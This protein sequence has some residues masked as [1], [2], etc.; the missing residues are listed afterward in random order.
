MKP[1]TLNAW[2]GIALLAAAAQPA[3]AA[4]RTLI[5]KDSEIAFSVKQMGVP[6]SGTFKRFEASIDLDSA[7]PTASR[8]ELTVDIASLDTGDDD[9]D[10]VAL[11]KP[12]LDKLGFPKATF[13]SS[14]VRAL[15]P[16]RYEATGQLAI[17]GKSREI[18]VPFETQDEKDG[19]TWVRGSFTIK[20]VDY[21]IGGGE[22]NQGDLVAPDV[23]VKFKL[24]LAPV[25]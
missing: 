24:K 8:A 21:G 25:R 9:A 11:D 12:W 16:N 6:V 13:K 15:G 14:A 19:S 5:A 3:L 22:W 10:A 18:T 17:R 2:L 4:S 20:R 23:P 1:V 7:Q